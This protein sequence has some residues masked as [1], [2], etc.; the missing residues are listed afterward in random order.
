MSFKPSSG[1]SLVNPHLKENEASLRN[2][3]PGL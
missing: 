3:S 2:C 1:V